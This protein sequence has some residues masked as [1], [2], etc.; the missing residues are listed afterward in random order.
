MGGV[1]TI[2][3]RAHGTQKTK[4]KAMCSHKTK[5]HGQQ[6]N[7]PAMCKTG[8]EHAANENTHKSRVHTRHDNMN[9]R[10]Q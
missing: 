10:S 4:T 2:N 3:M 6:N 8:H 5:T 1:K 9:A 7:S